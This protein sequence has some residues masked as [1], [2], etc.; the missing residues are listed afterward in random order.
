MPGAGAALGC[1]GAPSR[2]TISPGVSSAR[3]SAW[4][5]CAAPARNCA[6]VAGRSAHI[7]TEVVSP[8]QRHQR[9]NRT[10]RL[11]VEREPRA[12]DPLGRLDLAVPPPSREISNCAIAVPCGVT[13]GI[14]KFQRGARRVDLRR[15]HVDAIR[16]R[17]DLQQGL[18]RDRGIGVVEQMMRGGRRAARRGAI[19]GRR[20]RLRRRRARRE[21]A[22]AACWC[23][24]VTSSPRASFG[25]DDRARGIAEFLQRFLQ[26]VQRGAGASVR[27]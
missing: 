23:G 21:M 27:R 25:N 17:G 24:T 2:I 18:P 11:D 22:A 5:S 13:N 8:D 1:G 19:E 7:R 10:G 15:R 6:A 16:Q 9:V 3:L 14:S 26:Q 12:P 20:D 4:L